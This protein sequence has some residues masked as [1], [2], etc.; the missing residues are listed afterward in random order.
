MFLIPGFHRYV[1]YSRLQYI[2]VNH[3]EAVLAQSK[4]TVQCEKHCQKAKRGSTIYASR[5]S[6]EIYIWKTFLKLFLYGSHC[7]NSIK[8]YSSVITVHVININICE[9]LTE[10]QI[11]EN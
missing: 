10:R 1:H 5:N 2:I 3:N 4:P 9:E 6:Q 7:L 11:N 8:I